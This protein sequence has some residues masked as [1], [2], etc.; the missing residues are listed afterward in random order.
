MFT[1]TKDSGLVKM[2]AR[3]IQAGKKT[4]DDVP[5]ISNLKEMV[6]ERLSDETAEEYK[7]ITDEDYEA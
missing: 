5:D 7:L 3:Y 1:F 2:W 4:I 6:Q